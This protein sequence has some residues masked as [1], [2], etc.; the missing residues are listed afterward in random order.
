MGIL[1]DMTEA[2]NRRLAIESERDIDPLTGIL[3]RRGMDNTLSRLYEEKAVG[4]C[5]VV[6]IDAD[7]LKHIN[8]TYGHDSGDQYI[9]GIAQALTRFG[10]EACEQFA[11][12]RNGG[13]EFVMFLYGYADREALMGSVRA[14]LDRQDAERVELSNDLRVPLRYPVGYSL[15]TGEN[16]YYGDLFKAADGRMYENKRQRKQ[17]R[18][19]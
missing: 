8:D 13:D 10:K 1:M 5:A 14:L 2:V 11:V 4:H 6:M 9:R 17:Q 12:S 3:N 19:S 15:S 7:G 16:D 18:A